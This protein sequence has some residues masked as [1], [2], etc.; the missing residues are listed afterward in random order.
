MKI[1]ILGHLK[2]PIAK[3]YRGGLE[4][5]THAF[6]RRLVDRGHDVSLFASGDSDNDLPLVPI[7]GKSTIDNSIEKFGKV[8][9]TF[10]E[11]FEDEAYERLMSRL[12]TS[13]FDVIHNHSISPVPLELA[14]MLPSKL[15][16]TLHVPVLERMRRVVARRGSRACGRFINISHSNAKVWGHLLPN[17]TVIHNGVDCEFWNHCGGPRQRRAVWFGRIHPDKGT[18]LAIDAAHAA[19]LPIDVIGP[20]SDEAYFHAEVKPRLESDDVYHGLQ[21]HEG[22]CKIVGNASVAL[23]TP[24]WDEPFGLVVAEALACG[25]P[26]AAFARGAIPEILTPKVG[27]VVRCDNVASLAHGAL[28]CLRLHSEDCRVRARQHFSLQT[29]MDRYEAFYRAE[30]CPE[31]NSRTSSSVRVSTA[32][33][34]KLASRPGK[35]VA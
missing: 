14:S 33:P 1:A 15:I 18:A 35:L 28:Q 7:V 3:P 10:V 34:T 9:H 27:R 8:D 5:F 2:H 19:G 11:A 24:C 31:P 23:I 16:T 29:M 20:P 4:M 25:T 26:V 17:Q 6:V 22:I 13:D 30:N 32:V 21:T 12:A